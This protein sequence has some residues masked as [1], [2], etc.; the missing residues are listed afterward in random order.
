M[1][2]VVSYL[3]PIP[4]HEDRVEPYLDMAR[5][6]DASC[7]R[8]GHRHIVI[9]N[10]AGRGL[11]DGEAFVAP[12]MPANLMRAAI[13]GQ[14]QF[15]LSPRFDRDTVLVGVDCVF[16]RDP[17]EVFAEAEA[18]DAL[19]TIRPAAKRQNGLPALNNGAVYLRHAAKDRLADLFRQAWAI[20]PEG[21]GGDQWSIGYAVAP[22][23]DEV[24][25]VEDRRGL[26]VKFGGFHPYNYP[27]REG[28][29]PDRR[30]AYVIHFKGGR[31]DMMRAHAEAEGLAA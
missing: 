28:A 21:W 24:G 31:K 4:G 20:C 6:L 27:P 1:I 5:W 3:M 26:R 29:D 17:A 22:I 14:L 19:V 11:I 8:F 15:V 30:D 23:P 2:N 13:W 7:A 10:E 16:G 18:W 12:H 25:T 9:T